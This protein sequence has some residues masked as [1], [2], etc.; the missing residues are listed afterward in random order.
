MLSGGNDVT[1]TA[2]QFQSILHVIIDAVGVLA[3]T[4][5]AAER[6]EARI[7]K[8]EAALVAAAVVGDGDAFGKIVG[9]HQRTIAAQM[10]RFSRDET[11]VEELVH[12][13]FVEAYFSL[14]SYRADAP[15][16]HWLRKVAVRVGYRYWK[17]RGRSLRISELDAP[18]ELVARLNEGKSDASETLGSLLELLPV[19]DRLVLTLIYWDGCTI[20]EAA[21]LAGWSQ[22]MVKV[23]AFRARKR[24]RNLIEDSL[25]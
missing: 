20:A 22:S 2:A 14:K 17:R 15:F 21:D 23:Q 19:R 11:V 9:M 16:I 7:L 12:D 18:D 3:M 25:K 6:P 1:Q 8:A 10:K 4:E 5:H 24:L 13:V